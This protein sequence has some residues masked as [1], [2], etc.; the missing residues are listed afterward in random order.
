M[1]ENTIDETSMRK[2]AQIGSGEFFRV[3][4]NEALKNVFHRIDQYEKA[5]IQETRFKDTAD[6]YFV[7]LMWAIV[8]FILWLLLKSSF[9]SNA[10]QD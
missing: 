8:F 3:T 9:L 2:I 5:A 6:Y 10:L 1:V 4:D 7:Y